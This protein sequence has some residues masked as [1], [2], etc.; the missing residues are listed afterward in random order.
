MNVP[1]LCPCHCARSSIAPGS[2][3]ADDYDVVQAAARADV[4]AL[5]LPACGDLLLR[6]L[7][8]PCALAATPIDLARARL[9]AV[10]LA[11]VSHAA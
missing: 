6:A 5:P 10:R 2:F 11:V 1:R 3:G 9:A 7:L 4:A 8:D